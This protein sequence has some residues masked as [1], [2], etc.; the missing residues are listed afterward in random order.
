MCSY[1]PTNQLYSTKPVS[2]LQFM[3]M[4][5][6]YHFKAEH[7]WQTGHRNGKILCKEKLCTPKTRSNFLTLLE[8]CPLEFQCFGF[9]SCVFKIIVPCNN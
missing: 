4:K 1:C 2:I 5:P 7:H 6:E 9:W 3:K 8:L